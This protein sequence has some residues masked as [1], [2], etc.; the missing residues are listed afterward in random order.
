[1]PAGFLPVG[2]HQVRSLQLL[3]LEMVGRPLPSPTLAVTAFRAAGTNL[4]KTIT[5]RWLQTVYSPSC[6]PP[7]QLVS[8]AKTSRQLQFHPVLIM[9]ARITVTSQ[10]RSDRRRIGQGA[11]STTVVHR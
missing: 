6:H 4:L 8:G 5:T 10:M 1:M 7:R 9:K 11:Q 3:V 2:H